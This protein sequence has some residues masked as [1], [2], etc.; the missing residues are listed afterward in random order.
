MAARWPPESSLS[1]R[2]SMPTTINPQRQ[3][4]RAGDIVVRVLRVPGRSGVRVYVES[5]GVPIPSRSEPLSTPHVREDG[6]DD[7]GRRLDQDRDDPA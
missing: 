4:V 1:R 7:D 6:G 2:G 3:Q 5:G